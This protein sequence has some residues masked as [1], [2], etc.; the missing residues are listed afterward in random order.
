MLDKMSKKKMC[1]GLI[2]HKI[3]VRI[4]LY[5]IDA[6]S[7]VAANSSRIMGIKEVMGLEEVSPWPQIQVI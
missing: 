6:F 5:C 4:L 2:I 7:I 3:Q 1:R